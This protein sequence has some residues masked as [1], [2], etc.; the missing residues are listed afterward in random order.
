MTTKIN[1]FD[2]NPTLDAVYTIGHATVK[3]YDDNNQLITEPMAVLQVKY[4]FSAQVSP[5]Y[6]LV[7]GNMILIRGVPIGE[8]SLDGIIGGTHAITAFLQGLSKACNGGGKIEI[9]V[10]TAC[11]NNPKPITI[12]FSSAI[13]KLIGGT[14]SA[15]A[16]ALMTSVSI[17][18]FNMEIETGS[19]GSS[20]GS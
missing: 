2:A 7:T 11:E 20:S 16:P 10:K 17:Q 19:S 18:C 4:G 9:E 12:R 3:V 1:V 6:D 14:I 5:V 8:V 13:I 15:N